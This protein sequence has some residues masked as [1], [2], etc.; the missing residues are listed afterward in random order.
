VETKFIVSITRRV[1]TNRP[2]LYHLL[3]GQNLSEEEKTQE[4]L[5]LWQKER[6]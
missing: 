3:N 6:E 5:G 4:A 2:M 1:G